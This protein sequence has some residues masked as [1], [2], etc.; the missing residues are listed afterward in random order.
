MKTCNKS[1]MSQTV[2]LEGIAIT[3][4]QATLTYM[5]VYP[6][7]TPRSKMLVAATSLSVTN[8][9]TCPQLTYTP[10]LRGER[11]WVCQGKTQTSYMREC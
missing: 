4:G 9:S 2:F 3:A 1:I 5:Q 8:Y 6:E 7:E 11:P 10:Q